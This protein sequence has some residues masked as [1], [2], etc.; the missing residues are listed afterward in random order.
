MSYLQHRD[1]SCARHTTVAPTIRWP[2]EGRRFYPVVKSLPRVVHHLP[3]RKLNRQKIDIPCTPSRTPYSGDS[4][5]GYTRMSPRVHCRVGPRQD[6][7]RLHGYDS[8]DVSEETLLESGIS[9]QCEGETALIIKRLF[10]KSSGT[11]VRRE[12]RRSEQSR[13]CLI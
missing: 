11:R 13:F 6:Q 9:T 12:V 1:I 5:Y 4:G 10:D 3:S 8:P 2:S 7:P